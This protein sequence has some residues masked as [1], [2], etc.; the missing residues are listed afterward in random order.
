M[1]DKRLPAHHGNGGIEQSHDD[2][3]N[4]LSKLLRLT[5]CWESSKLNKRKRKG[6]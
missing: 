1:F 3:F 4:K 2:E 5:S 6:I